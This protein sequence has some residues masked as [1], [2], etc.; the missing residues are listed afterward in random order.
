MSEISLEKQEDLKQKIENY[1]LYWALSV[2]VHE[3][4]LVNIW[5]AGSGEWEGCKIDFHVE[6]AFRDLSSENPFSGISKALGGESAV[7]RKH[8]VVRVAMPDGTVILE[9]LDKGDVIRI[10]REG[11]WVKRINEY[12]LSIVNQQK[13]K[14]TGDIDF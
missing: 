13:E 6:K 3:R 11:A 10:F 12:A 9:T 5:E 7:I 8:E 2:V 14:L 1:N 4:E